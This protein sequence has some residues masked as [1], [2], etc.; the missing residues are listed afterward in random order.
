MKRFHGMGLFVV[1]L[2]GLAALLGCQSRPAV[3]TVALEPTA[4][5]VVVVV[6]A[7]SQP[8]LA[9]SA[10]VAASITPL[11]PLTAVVTSTVTPTLSVTASRTATRAIR[12]TTGP[13][14]TRPAPATN[15]PPATSAPPSSFAAP[16]VIAPEGKAFRDGDTLTFQFTAAGPLASDQC[17]RIDMILANPNGPGAVGDYWVGLCGNQ[18]G[19]GAPLAFQVLPGRFRDRANYGTLVVSAD[20]VIPPTPQYNMQWS[21]SVVKVTDATD[22]DHPKTVALSPASANLQDTFFR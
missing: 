20:S 2:G 3:P 9:P 4:P 11:P 6:T 1:G 12:P 15:A 16:Q 17:Y 7:T 18:A 10:T 13:G 19:A 21:V 22:S 8:T 14:A 5:V